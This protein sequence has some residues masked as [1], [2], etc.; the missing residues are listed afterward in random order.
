[1]FNR[2]ES[3]TLKIKSIDGVVTQVEPP[4]FKIALSFDL[5]DDRN[6]KATKRN[7][8]GDL[9]DCFDDMYLKLSEIDFKCA[10]C[11]MVMQES[12]ADRIFVS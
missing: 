5:W 11:K 2:H 12:A 10:A 9:V 1:M 6:A 3:A 7:S 4:K 8:N